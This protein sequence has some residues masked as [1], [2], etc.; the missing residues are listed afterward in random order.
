MCLDELNE[1]CKILGLYNDKLFA[2]KDMNISYNLSIM[3]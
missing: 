1:I 3:T 2:E